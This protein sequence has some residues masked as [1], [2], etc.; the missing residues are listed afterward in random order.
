MDSQTLTPVAQ[1]IISLIPITGIIFAFLLVFFAILYHHHEN[2]L[3]I[4]KNSYTPK[5]FNLKVFCQLTGLCLTFVG[6]VLS[7]MF[8][9]ITGI[10]WG[11]L[12]GLLPLAVGLALLIFAK[13][14]SQK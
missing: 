14:Y 9:F 12:A 13:I 8:F 7:I 6:F 5:T 2:K 3:R 10:S 11:L 1:I 4:L